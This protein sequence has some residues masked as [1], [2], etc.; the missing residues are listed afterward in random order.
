MFY[1]IDTPFEDLKAEINNTF[2]G[3]DYNASALFVP[4]EQQ[5]SFCGDMDTSVVDDLGRA[6]GKVDL[7]C[8]DDALALLDLV[9]ELAVGVGPCNL[10]AVY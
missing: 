4:E 9:G 6:A 1:S 10:V 2:A 8:V 5:L 7:P 3:L